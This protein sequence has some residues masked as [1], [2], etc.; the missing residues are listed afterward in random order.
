M[1][2]PDAYTALKALHVAAALAFGGGVLADA[3]ALAATRALAPDAAR[4]ACSVAFR[5]SRSVTTPAML[6]VWTAG[7]AMGIEGG[8]FSEPWLQAKL[9]GV[10]ILSG[11][12]GAHSGAL[13]RR[14]GGGAS[15]DAGGH[16]SRRRWSRSAA[17]PRSRCWR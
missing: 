4:V 6:I 17:W 1:T 7:L 16:A 12:H 2:L 11:L 5:W 15:R 14:A 9:V 3:L 10:L 8:W 13:R